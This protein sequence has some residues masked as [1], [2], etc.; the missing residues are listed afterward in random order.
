[1]QRTILLQALPTRSKQKR[2]AGFSREATALANRLL[3]QREGCKTFMAFHRKAYSASKRSTSFN[4]QVICDIERSVWRMKAKTA[5]KGITVKF[6]IPRNCARFSKSFEFVKLGTHPRNAVSIP[7]KPN[8]NL[9]RFQR[10]LNDGWE[11]KTIGLT[12]RLELA[13]YCTKVE[14]PLLRRRNILGIDINAKHFAVSVV[15]PEGKILYQTYFGR[16][17]YAKRKQV[18]ARRA[19]LQSLNAVKKF[20]R[21]QRRERDF[22]KT[23]LGQVVREI[24]RLALRFDADIAIENLAKFKPNG[25]RF[26]RAVMRIPFFAF[27]RILEQRCFDN[28]VTLDTIDSWHTSKWC[29][30]CGAV[31]NGHAANYSLFKCDCGLVVNSDRKASAAI[32]VK[33]L[34]ER[35]LRNLAFT[36]FSNRRVPVNG[37]LRP[38]AVGVPRPVGHEH[39]LTES[40][41]F[42]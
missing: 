5:V 27:K 12:P 14:L 11:C 36:Q 38:N 13:A 39:Q 7:V 3:A 42:Y 22:V 23:N 21:L 8:R 31:G 1:M 16:H 26:N 37:L 10:L 33:S 19:M 25:R 41:V 35:A 18:M 6:N 34:L 4:A 29:S 28:H 15:S 2:L 17:I 30:R 20:K 9:R 24:M 40:F 32:A